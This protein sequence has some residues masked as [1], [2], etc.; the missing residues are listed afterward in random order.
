MVQTQFLVVTM[1]LI[2]NLSESLR[3]EILCWQGIKGIQ[4]PVRG[5]PY[6]VEFFYLSLKQ[7]FLSKAIPLMKT[8]LIFQILLI[9]E[10]IGESCNIPFEVPHR[11]L[12]LD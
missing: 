9:V 3:V 10:Y 8:L 6:S 7:V 5:L 4:R 11:K 1:G 2:E 12:S